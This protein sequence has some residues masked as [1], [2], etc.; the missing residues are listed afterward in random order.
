MGN[1]YNI[2]DLA[3]KI[4][5]INGFSFKENDEGS[6]ISIKITGL[7]PGEKVHEELALNSANLKPTVHPKINSTKEIQIDFDISEWFNKLIKLYIK[8]DDN[9]YKK[10]I[11]DLIEL[12]QEKN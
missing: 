5:K 7:Q 12:H 9:D 8:N 1:P 2:Y 4:I 6:G 3:K 10:I 11:D